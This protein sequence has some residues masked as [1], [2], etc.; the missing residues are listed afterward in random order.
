MSTGISSLISQ[1][2]N[3]LLS[4]SH[5]CKLKYSSL[6]THTLGTTRLNDTDDENLH[7]TQVMCI[8]EVLSGAN[9]CHFTILL[10]F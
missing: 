6:C 9:K 2:V 5:S 1:E 8:K 4:C 3:G 10:V 7:C